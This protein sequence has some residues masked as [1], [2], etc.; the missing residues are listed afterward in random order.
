MK[1][2]Q[3]LQDLVRDAGVHPIPDRQ[4]CL[5]APTQP[6]II[7]SEEDHTLARQLLVEQRVNGPDYRD[8][9]KQ[10]KRIFRS[11]KEKE[12]LQDTNQWDFSQDELD[13]ALSA[14]I[15]KPATNPGLVQAFLNLG[16]K[17]NF[18]ETTDKKNKANKKPIVADRRRSTVL[19]RA[20]TV[21][22]ADSVSLLAAS[23][24]DQTTLDE[25]LK[26]ALAANNHP[27][28]QELL[29]HGADLNK[30]P[31][32]LADAVRANDQNFIRLLLRAPKALRPDI[33]SSCLPAAL[34]QTSEP[35]ISLLI[36][37]GA[38]PNFNDADALTM[39]ISQREYRLA[40]ALVAGSIP[41]SPTSL[42]TA[43]ETA[44]RISAAQDLYQFL[45]LLFCCGLSPM[46]P[47]L[48]ALL[49]AASQR[50]DV[51]MAEMFISHGVPTD[52]NESECLRSAV[53][54]SSWQL[55]NA[56]LS[57]SI[58]PAHASLALDA[59]PAEAP[60]ADRL[61]VI[62]TLVSKGANGRPLEKWLVRAVEDGDSTLMDLLLNAGAPLDHGNNRAIQAAV[63]RKDIR[64]LRTL[65]TSRPSS[66]SLAQVFPLIRSGYTAPERLMTVR[67]LLEHGARGPE[68]DQ[69]LVDAV[70]DTSSSRDVSLITELVRHGARVDHDSGKALKSV[71]SQA[72]VSTLRLLCSANP[73]TQTKSAAMP[74]IFD[75]NGDKRSTTS[76]MLELLLVGGVEDGPATQTLQI[77]V[78]GGS[79]NLGIIERLIAANARLL[80]HA[81]QYAVALNNVSQKG[82]ILKFLLGKAFGDSSLVKLLLS[83]KDSPSQITTTAAFRSLFDIASIRRNADKL[84]SDYAAIAQE[85]L[86]RGVD[87]SA[88]DVALRT[89]LDPANGISEVEQIVS[90]LLHHNA[91]VNAASGICFVFVAKRHNK[92]LFEKLLA[93]QP[94]FTTILPSLLGSGLDEQFLLQLMES[95]FSHGCSS[96]NLDLSHPPSLILAIQKYPR[97]DS[98]IEILLTHGCNPDSS[99]S[100]VVDPAVGEEAIT[101]IMWALA[102][103]QKLVSSSVIIALLKAGASST[104][105]T[106]LSE[107]API[108]LAAREGR[109]DI[110]KALLDH[111]ADASI[112]DKWDRSALSS[113][114]V[115]LLLH[116][117]ARCLQLESAAT[118]IKHGHDPN[119]P[120]RLHAG[121]N[122]LGELCLNAEL[123]NS[124]QRSRAR[125]L[126]RLF[127]DNGANPRFKARNERS[128]VLLAL[129]NAFDPLRIAEALLETEVWEQLNDEKHMFRDTQG[130]WYSPLS[131]IEIIP[132]PARAPQKQHLL[133]LLRDKGCE[134]KYYSE[135][136]DQPPGAIG[137]PTAIARLADRQK[138]HQLTLK[139]AKEASEHARMLEETEHIDLLRRKKEQQDAEMAAASTSAA[140]TQ[141]LSQRQH[142]FDM[143]RVREAERMKR[144]EKVAWHTLLTQQEH[145]TA[146]Q[147]AQIEERKAGAAFAAE[148]MLI[149]ARK[150]EV[151]HRAGVERRALKEK[152]EHMG[153]N[154]KMQ[155]Q[156]QDR[157]DESAKL[158]AGLRQDRKALEWGTVD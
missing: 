153:R 65:L 17:V 117:A 120:S 41:L 134:P 6:A 61:H 107:I 135:T 22:R 90:L 9:G 77:A 132:S 114:Q 36:G 138:E 60:K 16:A 67:L 105:I 45:Q 106:P 145:E 30:C 84:S 88:V 73:S 58:Q 66:Q 125:Q 136:E 111:G 123:K 127:L 72:D 23:G 44:M 62:S 8:P 113:T 21:R 124:S 52:L 144:A 101:A 96:E 118:L 4:P 158:H 142:E 40:V 87:Q 64:S 13:R 129:D 119:F 85:L 35:I 24:A 46:S 20:A 130:L 143:Q 80:G 2:R 55:A 146:A 14:V 149:E 78:R 18:V 128:A 115:H 139:L 109:S 104:R 108:A 140:H 42:Q 116:E 82:H 59:V 157:V 56:I 112:R 11:S 49:V 71:V 93:Y 75:T 48:G 137:L 103:P 74:L 131:Y 100:G 10:L 133:D 94:N 28:V 53:S 95:A 63:A 81:F 25:G 54:K 76:A 154:V 32:A 141:S 3:N 155:M 51:P 147:R 151:E 33:I 1:A 31:N 150:G 19:Q 126:L 38:D 50:N 70:A 47:R 89:F 7:A 92:P 148:K 15:D 86:S 5:P 98:L 152:E 39:A 26:A 83:G 122:G 27:C 121:R 79:D 102:Q 69:A 97:S 110:V 99:V 12:K 156:I 29:R 91:D 34:Q 57:T 37:H 43:F 68:V